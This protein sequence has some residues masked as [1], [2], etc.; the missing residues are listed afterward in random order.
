MPSSYNN[1]DGLEMR[2]IIYPSPS[3][4]RLKVAYAHG[5]PLDG[6]LLKFDT[7]FEPEKTLKKELESCK[8]ALIKQGYID[9]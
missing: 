9:E 2:L 4:N 5:N 8:S 7:I 6:K 3:T 1:E